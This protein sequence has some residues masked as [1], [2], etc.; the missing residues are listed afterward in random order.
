[1][2]ADNARNWRLRRSDGRRQ[3]ADS[4]IEGGRP[5][6]PSPPPSSIHVHM[7]YVSIQTT[8]LVVPHHLLRFFVGL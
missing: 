1:M 8:H 3:A 6:L 5:R 7:R 4:R 2:I